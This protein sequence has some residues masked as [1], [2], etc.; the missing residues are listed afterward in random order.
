MKS[1]TIARIKTT[2]PT[3]M[4]MGVSF[5]LMSIVMSRK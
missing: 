4:Y 3:P 1:T 2:A 5:L